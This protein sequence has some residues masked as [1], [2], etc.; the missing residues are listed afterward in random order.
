VAKDK[1]REFRL[2]PPKPP[3]RNER[4]V[5]STAYKTLMHYARMS[6]SQKRRA[7]PASGPRRTRSTI[8]GVPFG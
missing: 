7:G 1:E 3:A 2:R 8:R 4:A 5:W 6:G